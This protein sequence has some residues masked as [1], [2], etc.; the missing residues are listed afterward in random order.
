MFLSHNKIIFT[1]YDKSTI[2][3]K[4]KMKNIFKSCFETKK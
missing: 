4:Y 1:T 3:L 2:D